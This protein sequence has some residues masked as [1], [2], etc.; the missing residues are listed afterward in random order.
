MAQ[1]VRKKDINTKQTFLDYL[2]NSAYIKSIVMGK[3]L[4]NFVDLH[5]MPS[6]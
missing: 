4:L 1:I 5:K 2:V 6:N 3:K